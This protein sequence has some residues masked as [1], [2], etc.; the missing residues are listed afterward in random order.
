[1]TRIAQEALAEVEVESVLAPLQLPFNPMDACAPRGNQL[2]ARLPPPD[3]KRLQRHLQPVWLLGGEKLHDGGGEL[4]AAFPVQ[5]V[6]SLQSA[7]ADGCAVSYASVGREGCFGFQLLHGST[8]TTQAVAAIGGL[9][10]LLPAEQL[11]EEYERQGVLA[12]LL[13]AQAHALLAQ[14]GILCACNRR[15]SLEQ[16]L[17]CWLLLTHDRVQGNELIV[18]QEMIASLLGVRREGVTEAAR[19]LQRLGMIEYRRGH[20]FILKRD[21]L[22][23]RSCECYFGIRAQL[24]RS[25]EH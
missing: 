5:S 25:F 20:I 19:K 12:A 16:Q 23:A 11:R 14:S 17:A 10:Y 6:L 18:T 4:F 1:M 24:G 2:L 13:V 8:P 3:F 9:T 15:H 21:C 7:H 22:A